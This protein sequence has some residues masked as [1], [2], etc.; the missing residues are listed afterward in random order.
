MNL[1]DMLCYQKT[2]VLAF[3]QRIVKR[4]YSCYGLLF[5]LITAFSLTTASAQDSSVTI[6]QIGEKFTFIG[7]QIGSQNT[8]DGRLTDSRL[9]QAVR[10]AALYSAQ[11]GSGNTI[12]FSIASTGSSSNAEALFALEQIGDNHINNINLSVENVEISTLQNGDG[13]NIN[14]TGNAESLLLKSS[15]SGSG[16]A[17]TIKFDTGSYDVAFEQSGLGKKVAQIDLENTGG[18]IV[19]VDWKQTGATA[20]TN[21]LNFSCGSALGCDLSYQD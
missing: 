15:Q 5:F 6:N 3:I 21:N 16:H 9:N 20:D 14:I 18:G 4:G 8:L 10:G 11:T 17:A 2:K 13:T 1:S 12:N 7:F 19:T